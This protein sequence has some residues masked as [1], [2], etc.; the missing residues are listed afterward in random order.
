MVQILQIGILQDGQQVSVSDCVIHD[1]TG[2]IFVEHEGY[3][4]EFH[5]PNVCVFQIFDVLNLD[6]NNFILEWSEKQLTKAEMLGMSVRDIGLCQGVY[7]KSESP[8]SNS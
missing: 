7:S 1:E 8:T 6:E 2:H 5:D 4:F 3:T